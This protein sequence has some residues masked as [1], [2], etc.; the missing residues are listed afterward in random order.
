MVHNLST[1]N[2]TML[3]VAVVLILFSITLYSVIYYNQKEE[4]KL[5][6]RQY[7]KKMTASYIKVLER[8]KEFYENRIKANI[9]STGVKE[10]FYKRDRAKLYEL[11]LG[12]WNTLSRENKYLNVMHFHLPNGESF[13]RMHEPDKF[14]DKIADERPM[15]ARLHK[16]QE[17]L[18][19]FEAGIYNL[20]YR[21]FLPIFHND[22][23]IGALEFGS[24]PDQI[25]SEMK[26]FNGLSGA[27]FVR[28]DKLGLYKENSTVEVGGY[29]LQ[30]DT[31]QDTSTLRALP[32]DYDFAQSKKLKIKNKTYELYSFDL[33]D[34]ENKC[35]AKVV[36]FS[37][38]TQQQ[39]KFVDT[40]LKLFGVLGTLL[41]VLLLVIN[42]GFNKIITILDETNTKLIIN[43]N[44]ME[45]I[46]DNTA[47]SIIVTDINGLVSKFNK[48]AQDMLGYTLEEVVSRKNI[49]SFHKK[50]SFSSFFEEANTNL[51]MSKECIYITKDHQEIPVKIYLTAL[52]DADGAISG[53]IFIGEDI[54]EL[55]KSQ[56]QIHDYMHLIDENIITANT[57]LHANF[58]SVSQALCAIS[59][60]QKKELIGINYALLR[61]KDTSDTIYQNMLHA[62]EKNETYRVEMKNLKKNGGYFWVDMV[63]YPLFDAHDKKTGY[64][65]IMQDITNKKLV[66]EISITDGLTGIY[67]RRHFN[68]TFSKVIDSA[69]RKNDFLSFMILDIDYFKQYNDTYGHQKGDDAL[70]K[71]AQV[72]RDSLKRADD[73][74]FRLGGEE[75]GVLFKVRN[76]EEALVIAQRI[77]ENVEGLKIIH[78]SNTTSKYLTA[79]VGLVS[80]YAQD[81]HGD[82]LVFKEADD[83]LYDAKKAGRN[84]I[85]TNE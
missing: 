53:Y 69:K 45:S 26:Y 25:I 55:K 29:T 20:A 24:R 37:D 42:Y 84:T 1:K 73:Y 33:L 62:M 41:V 17:P 2:K 21:I 71:V 63:I 51:E 19:G 38:I 18:S 67:N 65:F 14:G 48:K 70:I 74:C 58:V 3:F 7:Y 22:T 81:M 11:S 83:L 15:V 35:A 49:T 85:V 34:F 6:E 54:T 9:R 79:S 46:L 60:Y 50:E 8:H 32:K 64:T 16:L 82:D 39:N 57:D 12:R 75:F 76:H 23:Y 44:F 31:M 77:K 36:F 80:K 78:K 43:Q 56:K 68:N 28:N 61:H 72:I 13:L 5:Q 10:A 52:R 27:L 40:A 4:L 59:G 47:H 66:E 30:Y